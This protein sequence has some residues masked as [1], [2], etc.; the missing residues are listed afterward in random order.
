MTKIAL[1]VLLVM[2]TGI[3]FAEEIVTDSKGRK[4][5]L[6]DDYTWEVQEASARK[7]DEALVLTKSPKSN[8]VLKTRTGKVTINY[9]ANE[10]RQASDTNASAEFSFQN[11]DNNGFGMLIYDG[12]PIPLATMEEVVIKNAN[13]IDPNASIQDIEKCVVNGTP[14]EL[15]T[16]QARSTGLDFTFFSF[17]ATKDTGTIQYTFYTLT[18]VFEKLRPSFLEAISGVEF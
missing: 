7:S 8:R 4:I 2:T 5:I 15:I 10:W 14:G 1:A 11:M 18:S 16:Y 3:S 17:V 6:H 13:N 9:N 12:L